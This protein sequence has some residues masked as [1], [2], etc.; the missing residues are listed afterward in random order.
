MTMW[1]NARYERRYQNQEL[2]ARD[3]S[4]IRAVWRLSARNGLVGT[5]ALIDIYTSSFR[6]PNTTLREKLP[7]D[8]ELPDTRCVANDGRHD[9]DDDEREEGRMMKEDV[10]VL[11]GRGEK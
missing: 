4:P 11:V 5:N 7:V 1:G 3:I 8:V 6:V 2:S 9:D 10:V